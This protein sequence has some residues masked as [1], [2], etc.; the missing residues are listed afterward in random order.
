MVFAP[1][2]WMVRSSGPAAL[3]LRRCHVAVVGSNMPIVVVPLPSQSPTTGIQ[4][5]W[6]NWNVG[7]GPALPT[8][9]QLP[10]ESTEPMFVLPLPSQSPVTGVQPGPPQVEVPAPTSLP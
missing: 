2:Y 9:Y 7:R 4:P 6:P 1:P 8:R 3:V 5:A 10:P